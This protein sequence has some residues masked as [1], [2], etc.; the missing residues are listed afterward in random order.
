[1][2]YRNEILQKLLKNGYDRIL[3]DETHDLAEIDD[4][5]ALFLLQI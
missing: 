2:Y 4:K 3:Y 5:S 1:M